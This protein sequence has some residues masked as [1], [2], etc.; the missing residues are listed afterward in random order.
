MLIEMKV[1]SLTTDPFTNMPIV[2]LTDS[3]AENGDAPTIVPIAIGVSE[4]K[5]IAME[6]ESVSLERPM[7]H[8][9]VKHVLGVCGA[10]LD[11][12]EIHDVFGD[13]HLARLIVIRTDGSVATLDSRASDAIALALRTGSPIQVSRKVIDAA[14]SEPELAELCAALS[15]DLGAGLDAFPAPPPSERELS[16]LGDRAFGKW[17]M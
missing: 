3:G 16:D 8:D 2:V 10:R 7:V 9:L 11:R 1:A 17:K 14:Q 13:T 15:M 12:V 6:L 4:A 5:A